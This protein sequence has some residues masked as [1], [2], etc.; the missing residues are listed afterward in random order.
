MEEVLNRLGKLTLIMLL[1]ALVPT[2]LAAFTGLR[3]PLRLRRTLGLL[4]FGHALLHFSWYLG[5]DWFFDLAAIAEDVVKH[6]FIAFGFSAFVLLVPL[7]ATST[8]G[9]VRRLGFDRWKR[10]HR[11]VYVAAVLGVVHFWFRVKADHL[12]PNLFGAA[13]A[14]LLA[15]R[16]P[17]WRAERRKR[18]RRRPDP[19][20]L[21]GP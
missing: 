11:L 7:A 5:V 12:E 9:M 19:A 13:L 18:A 1:V 20:R 4:A 2:P 17:G 3:W 21:P 16:I 6:K 14:V 8:D 15:A 10:L